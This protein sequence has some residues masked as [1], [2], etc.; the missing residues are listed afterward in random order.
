MARAFLR[1]KQH[2]VALLDATERAMVA[3]LMEQTRLI[4]AP[5]VESTGDPFTDLV[6]SMG[7]SLA[8]ED[9]VEHQSDVDDS[10]ASAAEHGSDPSDFTD[11]DPALDRLA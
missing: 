11:R 2:Y 1:Q 7:V 3:G 6:A 9:Q 4:L 10:D 5:E 8:I